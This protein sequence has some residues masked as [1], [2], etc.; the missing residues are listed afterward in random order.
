M[1]TTVGELVVEVRARV[2]RLATDLQGA[3]RD[4][5]RTMNGIKSAASAVQGYLGAIGINAFAGY[6]K[7]AIDA[8]GAL[9]DLSKK[10]GVSVEE[11]SSLEFAAKMSGTTLDG[12]AA[13]LKKLATNMVATSQGAISNAESFKA[14]GISVTDANGNLRSTQDVMLDVADRFAGMQDGAGKSALAVKLFGRSGADL[15]PMLNE[16]SKGI[17]KLQE[18]AKSLGLTLT[19]DAAAGMESLG[20]SMDTMA[21]AGQGVARQFAAELT[22]A[23]GVMATSL[24]SAATEGG[25]LNA[26]VGL[27]SAALK[28]VVSV[29]IGVVAV[30]GVLV[31]ATITT[32]KTLGDVIKGDFTTA[33]DNIEFLSGD[34]ATIFSEAG[35]KI[36]ATWASQ[37]AAQ[38]PVTA[39]LVEH[40]EQT[41]AVTVAVGENAN[42]LAGVVKALNDERSMLG[43]TA[44]QSEIYKQ[45]TAAGVSANSAAGKMIAT[46]VI[47]L[48]REREAVDASADAAEAAAAA[49]KQ[50]QD[51]VVSETKTLRD[52]VLALRQEIETTGMTGQQIEELVLSRLRE[53]QAQLDAII[54]SSGMTA[55][56]QAEKDAIAEQI[57]LQKEL[58]SL[59]GKKEIAEAQT[60]QAAAAKQAWTDTAKA[61]EQAL[62]DSL[63]RGFESGKSMVESLKDY[64]TNAFK[65]YV[66]K[67]AVQAIMG[68]VGSL[69]PGMASAGSGGGG[70][71]GALGSLGSISSLFSGAKSA[72]AGLFNQTGGALGDMLSNAR[73]GLADLSSSLGLD[74]LAGK[75]NAQGLEIKS[76]GA[77]ALDIGAN[78]GAGFLGSLAGNKLSAALFGERES[79][80]IGSTVGGVVGSGFGPIGTAI[81]SFLGALAEGAIGKIFGLGDQAKWGK[82]GITTGR[83][84][85]T[86]GSALQTITGASGLQLTAVAKRTDDQAALQLLQGF[87]A[88]DASLTEAAR[89]AGVT[90]DFTNTVLGNTNL[91][92]KNHGANNSF[93][94]GDRLDKFSAEKIETSADDFARAWVSEIDDQLSSRIKSIM[95]DTSKRT[96]GQIVELF[97]F[98]ATMDKLLSFNVVE[99]ASK[100]RAASESQSR[101]LDV[102][103]EASDRVRQLA[104]DFDGSTEAMATLSDALTQQKVIASQVAM[105]YEELAGAINNSFLSAIEEIRASLLTPEQTRAANFARIKAAQAELQTAMAPEQ[106]ASLSAEIQSLVKATFGMLDKEQ[107]TAQA[108]DWIDLL[109]EANTIATRQ[110]E[111][112]KAAL[113][114]SEAAL[115]TQADEQ[116]AAFAASFESLGASING[117]SRASADRWVFSI[118]ALSTRVQTGSDSV[119][120]AI[121]GLRDTVTTAVTSAATTSNAA[122]VA[123]TARLEAIESAA[124][125]ERAGP[126]G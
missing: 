6:I 46:K 52:K 78:L 86:E 74:K 51:A 79:T 53:R 85:P 58:V 112:G 93:G 123:L 62:T 65:T 35:A 61:I 77:N 81:G 40:E 39:G 21:M 16:G 48:V 9:F 69:I 124:R 71:S 1:S 70:A 109:T 111:A 32:F 44:V 19:D 113:A 28:S 95:G 50:H 5:S 26:V 97:G 105:A 108:Q 67:F 101:S 42:K 14:L 118:D 12:V 34:M 89:L 30:F 22:P 120:S 56:R 54:A 24:I 3:N 116:L 33:R 37:E 115:T 45:Q 25:V 102:Y 92:V 94:V 87:A 55:E 13:G 57:T 27:L 8:G 66:V 88:I 11:L 15:I 59:V 2:D 106:I 36:N 83:D 122:L 20:D 110:L 72:F 41:K 114:V 31:R 47:E 63:M 103:A 125:L 90:V 117:Q 82:L 104:T 98:A 49:V 29:V 73:F 119:V 18:T 4:V 23:L 68:T 7:S 96:A 43:M 99:E 100:A 76:F 75:F 91:N 126:N 84:T 60:A 121:S 10:T 80:G 64:I 38:K 107:Q 17:G